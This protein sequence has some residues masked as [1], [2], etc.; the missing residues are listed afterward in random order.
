VLDEE[1]L[2]AGSHDENLSS[3]FGELSESDNKGA[4]TPQKSDKLR[5]SGNSE[6]G[7]ERCFFKS[8][9]DRTLQGFVGK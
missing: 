9:H 3:R 1:G 7:W 8:F 6:I 5:R 4:K 2:V